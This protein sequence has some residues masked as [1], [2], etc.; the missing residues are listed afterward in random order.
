[1]LSFCVVSLQSSR[2]Y[3]PRPK[4]GRQLPLQ[5][6]VLSQ[7]ALAW[8]QENDSD[9]LR[10][11]R[12][13]REAKSTPDPAV[14]GPIPAAAAVMP[15]PLLLAAVA[16]HPDAL[17][18]RLAAGKAI[19]RG[20][21]VAARHRHAAAQLQGRIAGATAG[22]AAPADAAAVL[23]GPGG[24]DGG[25]A[26]EAERLWAAGADARKAGQVTVK[27]SRARRHAKYVAT[28]KAAAQ[29]GAAAEAEASQD[30]SAAPASEAAAR[31]ISG[32][33]ALSASQDGTILT[34]GAGTTSASGPG[35]TSAAEPTATSASG[36]G[37]TSASG[38]IA[39]SASGPGATSAASGRTAATSAALPAASVVNSVANAT[40][41]SPDKLHSPE[42]L[43]SAGY[44]LTAVAV[45]AVGV[46]LAL[47]V[48][49]VKCLASGRKV[50]SST[51]L[52][53]A[54][55]ARPGAAQ[56]LRTPL[57]SKQG[58]GWERV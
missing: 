36:P 42:V 26:K 10:A 6:A 38:A 17:A 21:A 18:A 51:G 56:G 28:A 57:R 49:A 13:L 22:R 37:A 47:L 52:Q 14:T 1:M 8:Q 30:S 31:S 48:W 35:A 12:A 2:Q 15:T 44:A 41:S 29:A 19:A 16:E 5:A 54:A 46:I 20:A 34:P 9:A 32:A 45:V 23:H 25:A 40:S 7:H 11:H 3:L 58:A 4:L 24:R 39:T 55:G 53:T 50:D 43:A 27:E 33:G